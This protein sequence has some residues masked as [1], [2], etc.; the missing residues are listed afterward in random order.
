[1][2]QWH[3][4][5]NLNVWH[6]NDQSNSTH[7]YYPMKCSVTNSVYSR[8]YS[9]VAVSVM[10]PFC[11]QPCG[12]SFCFVSHVTMTMVTR[13]FTWVISKMSHVT[14][15][16]S[17]CVSKLLFCLLSNSCWNSWS[18][19]INISARLEVHSECLACTNGH[20]KMTF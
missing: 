16:V 13:D 1:M 3:N 2:L 11:N 6:E 19:V 18:K 4:L 7:N 17:Q 8:D 10:W 5:C 20:F 9:H 12:R 15:L 14:Y